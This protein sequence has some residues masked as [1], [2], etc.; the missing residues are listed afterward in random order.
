MLSTQ[1]RSAFVNK[2]EG[3]AGWFGCSLGIRLCFVCADDLL[4]VARVLGDFSPRDF[5][6]DIL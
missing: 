1:V 2:D 6:F 4:D 5:V 3:R